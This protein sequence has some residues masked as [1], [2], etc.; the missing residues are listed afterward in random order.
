METFSTEGKEVTF[1]YNII[2]EFFD[3][4]DMYHAIEDTEHLIRS[5]ADNK[6]YNKRNP[7]DLFLFKDRFE[8]LTVAAFTIYN[9]YAER[10]PG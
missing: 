4:I 9:N 6:V 8:E 3:D 10:K 2:K 7:G 1:A 5:A